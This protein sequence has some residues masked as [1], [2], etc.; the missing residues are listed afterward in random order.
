VPIAVAEIPCWLGPLGPF[1]LPLGATTISGRMRLALAAIAAFGTAIAAQAPPNYYLT[2]N[3]STPATLRSTLH[4]VIDDHTRIPYTAAVTDTWDVLEAADQHPT[5][6]TQILDV[7]KNAAYTKVTGGNTNYDR[8]HT[9]PKSYGFPDEPSSY[10]HTDCHHLF[11]CAITHNGARGNKPYDNGTASWT[12]WTT[13]VNAGQGGGTGFPGNSNWTEATSALGSWQTWSSRKGDVARALMYMDVRYEGGV[14]GT[15]NLAE[16]DL[17]LTDDRNLI[18][19]SVTSTNTSLAYMGEL[20]VLLQWH[21][22]DPVDA[23]EMARNNAVFAHQSNRNPFIDHPE[24]AACLFTGQC[25]V[26][27]D[28]DVWINELHYDNN[29]TDVN[30]LVEVAGTRST[31]LEGWSLVAYNGTDGRSY[32]Q[33]GLR[34]VIP[35]Q[36]NGYGARTFLFPGLQNGSPDGIALVA[37]SGKV[38]QFL[39][40]EGAFTAIDGPAIGRVSTDLGVMETATSTVG[41]SLQLG[42]TGHSYAAFSWQQALVATPGAANTNQTFQ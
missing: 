37:P 26:R 6:S 29:G 14:H 22:Q 27:A 11:L 28:F 15:T 13:L 41:F 1:A 39:S 33:I 9:W 19:A 30:E 5:V 32:A 25:G 36:Q 2:V 7:Y 31:S 17:R 8:E 42:G 23:K 40:Y 18:A 35:S 4:A 20:S 10:P 3:P 12:A 34:G 21:A 24:W 38:V 16:P